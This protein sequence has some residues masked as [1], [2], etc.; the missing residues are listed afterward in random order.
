MTVKLLVLIKLLF[1]LDFLSID[2]S[3]HKSSFLAPIALIGSDIERFEKAG[4]IS[5]FIFRIKIS[6]RGGEKYRKLVQK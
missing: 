6:I 3:F 1:I 2:K 5:D 4:W